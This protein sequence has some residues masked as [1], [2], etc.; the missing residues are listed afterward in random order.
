MTIS[1]EYP[2]ANKEN[3]N[4]QLELDLGHKTTGYSSEWDKYSR[5]DDLDMYQKSAKATAIYPRDYSI[6]Y[7]AIGLAGEA[8][9][10]ANKV[11]K[12]IRDNPDMTDDIKEKIGDEI[13]DVL[14]YCAVLADDLGQS[15]SDIANR[16]LLKLANRQKL[17]KLHGSGDKR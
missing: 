5:L 17:G 14:W 1:T 15:L 3:K 10:V 9:E 11:K 8:G 13:G 4:G 7:P 2:E 12:L 16:N 6:V